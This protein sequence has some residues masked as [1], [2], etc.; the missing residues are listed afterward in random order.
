MA[1]EPM[2]EFTELTHLDSAWEI[3]CDYD[4]QFHCG[5]AAAWEMRL[6][7]NCGCKGVRLACEDC[8]NL[9]MA[10]DGA[11]TCPACGEVTAPARHIFWHVAAL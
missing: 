3:V 6:A 2:I 8:K 10:A 9:W 11:A 5:A 1:T 4:E 7:C